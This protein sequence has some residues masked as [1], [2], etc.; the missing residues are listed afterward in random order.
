MEAT[1]RRS[2]GSVSFVVL[3]GACAVFAACASHSGGSETG[4]TMP[5]PGSADP[6]AANPGDTGAVGVA[7][8]VAPGVTV[9]TVGYT[10]TGPNGFSQSGTINV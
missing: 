5:S 4:G 2:I 10:L 9:N 1:L 8:Q 6:S 3:A 7:L